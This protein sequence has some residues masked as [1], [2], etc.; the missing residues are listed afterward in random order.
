M[1]LLLLLLLFF[2]YL[3]LFLLFFLYFLNLFL[4]FYFRL[5]DLGLS[6]SLFY[7]ILEHRIVNNDRLGDVWCDVLNGTR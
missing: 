7:H 2:L 3:F 4:F 1:F 5:G 6:R